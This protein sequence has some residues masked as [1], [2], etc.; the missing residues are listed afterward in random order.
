M[1]FQ[2]FIIHS[3]QIS[4]SSFSKSCLRFR[5]ELGHLLRQNFF[6]L[7]CCTSCVFKGHENDIIGF[8]TNNFN[9]DKWK[10][11]CKANKNIENDLELIKLFFSPSSFV[12]FQILL[13]TYTRDNNDI[14]QARW[15]NYFNKEDNKIKFIV[16]HGNN[17]DKI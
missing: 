16:E 11:F 2:S 17:L 10:K 8:N 13:N 1:R 14:Q 6:Q 7:P 4:E 9:V 15:E 12:E 3:E 5:N